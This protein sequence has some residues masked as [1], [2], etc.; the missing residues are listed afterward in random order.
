LISQPIRLA[1]ADSHPRL[2][3]NSILADVKLQR[4]DFEK[5]HRIYTNAEEPCGPELAHG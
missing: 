3:T 2:Q 1:D 4:L 5:K